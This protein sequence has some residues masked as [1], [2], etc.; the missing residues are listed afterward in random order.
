MTARLTITQHVTFRPCRREDLPDLE[1]F[2]RF[3]RYRQHFA[4]QFER[5]LRGENAMLIAEANGFPVGRLSVDLA[6][7]RSEAT[8][9]LWSFE[10]LPPMRNL[11]IGSRLM[12][13]AECMLRERG[14]RIAEIG[15]GKD[16]PGAQRLYERL[17]YR[18][19][20]ENY[21]AWDVTAPDGSVIHESSDEWFLQKVL[22][23][24]AA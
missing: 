18:V 6:K 10:V 12:A 8:G 17:G 16:N 13:M 4:E 2:G 3:A 7:R 1:W 5:Q 23:L 22:D 15:A 24:A 11:G 14:Y 20:G 19:V 21:E 9:V